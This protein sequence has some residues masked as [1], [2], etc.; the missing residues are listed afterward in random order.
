MDDSLNLARGGII[1]YAT[2]FSL[3]E[4]LEK[5]TDYVPWSAVS[6]EFLSSELL[7]IKFL[8]HNI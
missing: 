7:L 6:T 5:E 1:R 4:Y 8:L 3:L 2:A